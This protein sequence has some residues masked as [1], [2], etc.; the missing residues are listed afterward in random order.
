MD[1]DDP[2]AMACLLHYLYTM[3]LQIVEDEL[4]RCG[5]NR[6]D[7]LGA[8]CSEISQS[9]I[10]SLI[11]IKSPSFHTCCARYAIAR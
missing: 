11:N 1:E 8:E 6:N 9:Y 3:S 7:A 2:G 10:S 5:S 4:A